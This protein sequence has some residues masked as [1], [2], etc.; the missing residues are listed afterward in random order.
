MTTEPRMDVGF[1]CLS[2]ILH[3]A[4]EEL[5]QQYDS[6][7]LLLT[8]N[9][10]GHAVELVDG[11]WDYPEGSPYESDGLFLEQECRRLSELEDDLM[12][13]IVGLEFEECYDVSELTDMYCEQYVARRA[14]AWDDACRTNAVVNGVSIPR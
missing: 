13:I 12:S 7:K 8:A 10:I 9:R 14:R 1:Y 5:G 2:A 4:R 11:S 6:M 3:M